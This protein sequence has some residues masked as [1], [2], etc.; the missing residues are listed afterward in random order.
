[1]NEQN[2]P[3][4][5]LEAELSMESRVNEGIAEDIK[6]GNVI[7]YGSGNDVEDPA[8]LWRQYGHVPT[9]RIV[10]EAKKG[11][12]TVLGSALSPLMLPPMED[13]SSAI[14]QSD[15]EVAIRLSEELWSRYKELLRNEK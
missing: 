10:I 7:T 15:Q 11:S 14:D 1:M 3:F 9:R 8:I 4:P 12:V 5:G 2:D 13:R 6:K